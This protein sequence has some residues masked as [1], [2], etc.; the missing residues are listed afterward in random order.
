MRDQKRLNSPLCGA[1][2]KKL[3]HNPCSAMGITGTGLAARMRSMPALNSS[4][5]PLVVSLP[6]GKM[7][8]T[9]PSSRY[10]AMR[11]KACSNTSG[12]SLRP[13]IGTVP[14][15]RKMKFSTGRL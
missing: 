14:A 13:A 10:R 7:H 9:S 11:W 1:R 4:I 12:S 15:V 3:P 8:T 6:S 5:S 2:L